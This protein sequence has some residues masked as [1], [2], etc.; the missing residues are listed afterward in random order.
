MLRNFSECSASCG[1][2]GV[3][4]RL[5]ECERLSDSER[6]GD[7]Y[8]SFSPQPIIE[9][10]CNRFD[11]VVNKY[12]WKVTK[13]WSGCSATCGNS[14]SQYQLYYCVN[15]L[16]DSKTVDER[17]C[18]DLPSPK[19]PRPCNI[20]PCIT[21]EWELSDYWHECNETCGESGIQRKKLMCMK[22]TSNDKKPTG[23]WYCA[24][25]D[26]LEETRACN[27]R[28]CFAYEWVTSYWSECSQTCGDAFI[29]RDVTC[30]NVTFDDRERNVPDKY[31]DETE[32]PSSKKGC[33]LKPCLTYEWRPTGNWTECSEKCG[34]NG[35]QQ[36]TYECHISNGGKPVKADMCHTIDQNVKDRPCNRIPCHTFEWRSVRDSWIPACQKNC[37]E[38]F[39][40][41]QVQ[42]V[43]CYQINL[44]GTEKMTGLEFCKH[45]ERPLNTRQCSR[46]DCFTYKWDVYDWSECNAPCGGSGIQE[47]VAVCI[48]REAND[49]QRV[50][51]GKCE[52]VDKPTI[53]KPC[54]KPPCI[55]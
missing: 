51:E 37:N 9:E 26:K 50:S 41:M 52:V 33:D 43:Q 4:K 48:R 34:S 29:E 49:S 2:D 28:K 36:Q 54:S 46:L 23:N 24:A 47:G 6:V 18:S 20:A 30:K 38:D 3:R 27:R 53:T 32:K 7:E 11:C 44:N 42:S 13:E 14:G 55:G 45:I 39:I 40:E 10:P 35:V 15:D 16:D 25:K 5:F 17:F 22:I 31:C 8:C 12:R 19:E 21:Y 1:T